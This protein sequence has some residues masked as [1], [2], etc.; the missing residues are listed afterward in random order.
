MSFLNFYLLSIIV[1]FSSFIYYTLVRYRTLKALGLKTLIIILCFSV[2]PIANL[3][4][5]FLTLKKVYKG[6]K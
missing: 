6:F 3:L 2:I 1:C 4:F 5:T